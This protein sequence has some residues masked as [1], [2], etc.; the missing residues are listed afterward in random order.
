MYLFR[1]FAV[2]L[3]LLP[4]VGCNAIVSGVSDRLRLLSLWLNGEIL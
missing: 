4:M 3:L 2:S 1:I